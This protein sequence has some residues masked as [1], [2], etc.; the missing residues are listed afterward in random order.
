MCNFF[1]YQYGIFMRFSCMLLVPYFLA[2]LVSKILMFGKQ[3]PR[4]LLYGGLKRQT[5]VLTVHVHKTIEWVWEIFRTANSEKNAKCQ[6]LKHNYFCSCSKCRFLN[7][8]N[9]PA[10]SVV[11]VI[12]SQN[13]PAYS[14]VTLFVFL[15]D[16]AQWLQLP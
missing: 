8:P 7:P 12:L 9:D 11:T 6:F 15:N 1:K 4:C 16:P 13:D 5:S 3:L 14:V 2:L 10:Y